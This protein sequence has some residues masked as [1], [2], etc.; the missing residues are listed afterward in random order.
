MLINLH[1]AKQCG[2]RMCPWRQPDGPMDIHSRGQ[3]VMQES[4]EQQGLKDLFNVPHVSLAIF[5]FHQS[6]GW[7]SVHPHCTVPDSTLGHLNSRGIPADTP[8]CSV[9]SLFFWNPLRGS[10]VREGAELDADRDITSLHI[11]C[12]QPS[13]KAAIPASLNGAIKNK[14]GAFREIASAARINNSYTSLLKKKGEREEEVGKST[15]SLAQIGVIQSR[16]RLPPAYWRQNPWTL[17]NWASLIVPSEQ[18]GGCCRT[19]MMSWRCNRSSVWGLWS[20]GRNMQKS[21]SEQLVSGS[22]QSLLNRPGGC[23]LINVINQCESNSVA[24]TSSKLWLQSHCSGSVKSL[25]LINYI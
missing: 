23:T 10:C 21:K 4:A 22:S 8:V 18:E 25:P 19:V 13:C 6:E 14:W 9:C 16:S 17:W 2:R 24:V 15:K 7:A 1:S 11:R 5:S 20:C 12:L 3:V